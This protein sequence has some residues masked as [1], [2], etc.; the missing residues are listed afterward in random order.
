MS[1]SRQGLLYDRLL[2]KDKAICSSPLIHGGNAKNK[3]T[4]PALVI[5]YLPF[6]PIP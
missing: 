5:A 4:I 3:N 1:P 6:V 2:K